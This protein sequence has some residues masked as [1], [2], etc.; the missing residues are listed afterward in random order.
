MAWNLIELIKAS[1]GAG[2]SGQTFRN[3]VT[4]AGNGIKVSDYKITNVS[5]SGYPNEGSSYNDNHTFS[6]TATVTRNTQAY[7]IQRTASNAF[8]ITLSYYSGGYGNGSYTLDS[9]SADGSPAGSSFS[10]NIRV[11]GP[12]NTANATAYGQINYTYRGDGGTPLSSVP[13]GG[14]EWAGNYS[15]IPNNTAVGSS[16]L[17]LRI[18]YDPDTASFNPGF[19][20]N[21]S[22]GVSGATGDYLINIA[23]RGLLSSDLEVNWYTTQSAA[24][25]NNTSSAEFIASG[26]SL[27][28]SSY[29][30]FTGTNQDVWYTWR[31][32][33]A[34]LNSWSSPVN[35]AVP[36]TRLQQ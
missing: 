10:L 1:G 30:I 33:G 4:G 20:T 24:S 35:L 5:W 26:T 17:S 31:A 9:F 19:T 16:Q 13:A 14:F 32:S 11:R 15:V 28:W 18:D 36:E 34:G 21:G 7:R 25:T 27:A 2:S 23:N 3:N 29:D 22:I 8:T 12:N 6:I